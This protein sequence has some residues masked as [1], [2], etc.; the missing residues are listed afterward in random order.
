MV[1]PQLVGHRGYPRHY[2]ENTLIGIEAAIRAGARYFEIDVQL[3]QDQ[4]PV[5]FHDRDLKRLCGVG[6]AVHDYPFA[7]LQKFR[8]SEPGRFGEK[9]RDVPI[10]TLAELRQLL[11]QHPNVTGFI[12]LKRASLKHFGI[13]TMLALVRRE[14]EP[15]LNQCV[16]I[17]YSLEALLAA[18]QQGWPEIGV[19][20]DHWQEREQEIVFAIRP[21]Y[22]FCDVDGLPPEG[23]LH[24]AGAKL[25][26]YEV[27]DP[28]L[29]LTLAARGVEFVETFA[30]GEMQQE[31]ERLAATR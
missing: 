12:E 17:S 31:I 24:H 30:V 3:T 13:D 26:V 14:L 15:V 29:A 11:Q 19:V 28:K 22:L 21:Q 5:L 2:P 10:T 8:A 25:A 18:R 7:A 27:T 1:I 9:Y 6:G 16:L 23:R 4:V 20:V